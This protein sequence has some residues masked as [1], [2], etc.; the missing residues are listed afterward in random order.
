MKLLGLLF[1]PTVLSGLS[2]A[3]AWEVQGKNRCRSFAVIIRGLEDQFFCD[4]GANI[5]GLP[6][7]LV[8]SMVESFSKMTYA[9][10]VVNLAHHC[11][12]CGQVPAAAA[13]D[14]LLLP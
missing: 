9:G 5:S 14:V 4:I 11:P 6:V 12:R 13:A 3:N 8:V 10:A 1:I 7:P 2:S